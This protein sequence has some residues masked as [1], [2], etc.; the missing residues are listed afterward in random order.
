[1]KVLYFQNHGL[2][3]SY[4]RELKM[5]F[6]V[7]VGFLSSRDFREATTNCIEL[8]QQ[9]NLTRWLADNREMKAIRQAD[10]QWFVETILPVLRQ[11]SLKRMA[12]LVS[13]DIFNQMAIDHIYEEA[14]NIDHIEMRDFN[15]DVKAMTWLLRPV[16]AVNLKEV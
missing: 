4:D 9:E 16:E 3:L 6:A 2:T 14:G 10:Q 15:D 8:I 7:W 5:G 12:T 13:D 1:M 11:S